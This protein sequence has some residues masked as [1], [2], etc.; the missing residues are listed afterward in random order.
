M[1][2]TQSLL[3]LHTLIFQAK[4]RE[5][6]IHKHCKWAWAASLKAKVLQQIYA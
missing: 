5:V 2:R 4:F 1:N 6:P 3:E